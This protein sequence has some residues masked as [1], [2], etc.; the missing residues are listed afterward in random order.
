MFKFDAQVFHKWH[1]QYA[2]DNF[3]EGVHGI[4]AKKIMEDQA[5]S[6]YQPQ[7]ILA[8]IF[9]KSGEK[10]YYYQDIKLEPTDVT[11]HREGYDYFVHSNCDGFVYF[12][13]SAAA[14][15]HGVIL[16]KEYKEMGWTDELQQVKLG[17]ITG[18][19]VDVD[20]G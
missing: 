14:A 1:R 11:T 7:Y 15:I 17:K 8:D 9:T 3:Y 19:V 12:K 2:K 13:T 10:E 6:S 5:E 20:F 16:V 18:N 4:E